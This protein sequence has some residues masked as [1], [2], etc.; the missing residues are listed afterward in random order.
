MEGDQ[1]LRPPG[2]HQPSVR[3]RRACDT[4]EAQLEHGLR[5]DSGCARGLYGDLVHYRHRQRLLN[6]LLLNGITN[7]QQFT[8]N[9]AYRSRRI[10]RPATEGEWSKRGGERT[11]AA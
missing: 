1:Q 2:R 11:P 8:G 6:T 9:P 10:G 7:T 3:K 5:L 4:A